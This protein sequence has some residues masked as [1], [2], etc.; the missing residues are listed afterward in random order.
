MTVDERVNQLLAGVPIEEQ[1]RGR[2][3]EEAGK[4]LGI[5]V[6]TVYRAI[7]DRRLGHLKVEGRSRKGRGHAGL[8]RV[9]LI[10]IVRFQI[11]NEV[12]PGTTKA[13]RGRPS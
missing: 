2:L 6:P 12:M 8:V 13:K 5:A 4:I 1:I 10:D 9:R 7:S 3:V 11:Q